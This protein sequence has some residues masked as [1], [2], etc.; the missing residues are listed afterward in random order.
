MNTRP[1]IVGTA[2]RDGR[3]SRAD[4]SERVVLV[5]GALAGVG[6][7]EFIRAD[8]SISGDVQ[9]LVGGTSRR[10]ANWMSPS[11]TPALRAADPSRRDR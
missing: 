7:G 11:A 6:A 9:A 8:V 3:R 1:N 4:L 2:H 10:S 5:T